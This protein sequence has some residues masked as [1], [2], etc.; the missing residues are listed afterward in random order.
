MVKAADMA[1]EVI[2]LHADPSAT[3]EEQASRKRRLLRGPKEFRELRRDHAEA[4]RKS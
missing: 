2:D 1:H 3:P 4:K